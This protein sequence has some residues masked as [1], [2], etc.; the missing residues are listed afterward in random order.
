MRKL[1]LVSTILTAR[2][3]EQL[4]RFIDSGEKLERAT[5]DFFIDELKQMKVEALTFKKRL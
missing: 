2:E 4:I 1:R 5:K 3:I